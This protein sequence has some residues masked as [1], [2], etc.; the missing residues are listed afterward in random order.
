[1]VSVACGREELEP[2]T[3]PAAAASAGVCLTQRPWQVLRAIVVQ[4]VD[5]FTAPWPKHRYPKCLRIAA[6]WHCTQTLLPSTSLAAT[7]GPRASQAF[8]LFVTL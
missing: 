5:R 7:S 2:Q 6:S 3:Q 1:M 8:K 4:R